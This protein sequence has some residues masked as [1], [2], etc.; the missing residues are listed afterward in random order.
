MNPKCENVVD[1]SHNWCSMKCKEIFL[2]D[3]SPPPFISL[4]L[5]RVISK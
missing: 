3:Y 5:G 2:L 4:I 1:V